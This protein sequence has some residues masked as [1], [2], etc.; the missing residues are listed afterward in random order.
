MEYAF[1]TNSN[2]K[3]KKMK[4]ILKHPQELLTDVAFPTCLILSYFLYFQIA[5]M[6]ISS[7]VI[8][9]LIKE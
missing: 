6:P 7:I 9:N 8:L 2:S 5:K 1:V 3:K 4:K